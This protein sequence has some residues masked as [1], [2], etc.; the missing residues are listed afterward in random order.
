MRTRL[1]IFA[2]ALLISMVVLRVPASSFQAAAPRSASP[3][4]DER[5][6][7]NVRPFLQTYCFACHS[8]QEPAAGLDL[9]S[10]SDLDAVTK[11]QRRWSLVLARLKA[12]E[13]PPSQ[14]RQ[15]PTAMQVQ[16]VIDWI[17][18][19]AAQ[20]ARRHPAIRASCSRGG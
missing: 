13:M 18:S 3:S 11:D 8:G 5:F 7:K 2:C 16:P 20:E 9:T 15:H 17:Q 10:E 6:Q 14:A 4:L 19:M 1:T 12:G